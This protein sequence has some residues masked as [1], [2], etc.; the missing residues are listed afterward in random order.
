MQG[1][2]N[3]LLTVLD[4][5]N[6][7]FG[8]SFSAYAV[9]YIYRSAITQLNYIRY[10]IGFKSASGVYY[11]LIV[12][13]IRGSSTPI[14]LKY[15]KLYDGFSLISADSSIVNSVIQFY[16]SI[17]SA[18]IKSVHVDDYQVENVLVKEV[19]NIGY[20]YKLIFRNNF[21]F[22]ITIF[23]NAQGVMRIYGVQGISSYYSILIKI[24]TITYGDLA[25]LIQNI[26]IYLTPKPIL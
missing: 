15:T 23:V 13:L 24:S 1:V 18:Q 21:N 4:F 14:L 26:R 7:K 6:T 12:A 25:T 3:D 5:V 16:K 17:L 20:F 22:S 8:N 19:P 9:L 10:R 11:E 2:D